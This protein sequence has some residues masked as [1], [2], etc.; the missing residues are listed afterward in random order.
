MGCHTWFYKKTDTASDDEIKK[1]MLERCGNEIDFLDRL[2]NK[3]ESIDKDLLEGYPE[4]T[5][6]WAE[7]QKP[8]WLDLIESTK[9]NTIT[10]DELYDYYS[11]WS[12][13]LTVYVD[14]KGFYVECGDFHDEF[15]KY[16]YPDDKL[17]SLRETLDYINNPQN[18][19]TVYENTIERLNEFWETYP[20]GLIE[21]G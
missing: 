12:D 7:N 9:N 1:I 18:E 5:P 19:C 20:D 10:K 11:S 17:F 21:F 2:I 16:G 4:W 8:F 13:G 15:R 14:G 3:R 6:E